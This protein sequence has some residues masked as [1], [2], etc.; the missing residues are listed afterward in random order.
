MQPVVREI[1]ESVYEESASAWTTFRL[2]PEI[3]VTHAEG[4]LQ[5]SDDALEAAASL[6]GPD[7]Y[8]A[9]ACATGN[10]AA[11]KEFIEGVIAQLKLGRVSKSPAFNEEIRQRLC[12]KLLV[13]EPGQPPRI[14]EYA[15]RGAL[16]SWTQVAAV[17]VALDLRRSRHREEQLTTSDLAKLGATDQVELEFLKGQYQEEF[18]ASLE[19]S[20]S[21]LEDR[22]RTVLRMNV[23][24][25]LN[26]AEIGKIYG[27]HR[28]TV[29]R[30]IAEAREALFKGTQRE[31][32]TRLGKSL[33]P[34]EFNSLV[35][36]VL[37]RLDI[38][39]HRLLR[40]D[41]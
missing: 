37:S 35:G 17:R 12:Q 15:G 7:L 24:D 16:S 31:L 11:M 22:Q 40:G 8:L 29:A 32:E 27:V 1:L 18:K 5:D 21:G 38:S 28:A 4:H 41:E 9:C 33:S 26:I 25:R 19:R 3:F 34:S 13:A 20:F 36:L 23:V 2:E 39:I 30:W 6:R 14:G 10:E